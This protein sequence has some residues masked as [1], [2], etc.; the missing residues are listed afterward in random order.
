MPQQAIRV[1]IVDDSAVVRQVMTQL[2]SSDRAISVMEAVVKG[3]GARKAQARQRARVRHGAH[4]GN[5]MDIRQCK[6]II[7]IFAPAPARQ[8]HR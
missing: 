2:L 5:A 1:L 6:R 7:R 4:D 3:S 8:A